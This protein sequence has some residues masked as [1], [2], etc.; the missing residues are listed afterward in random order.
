MLANAPLA[1]RVILKPSW[2]QSSQ[3]SSSPRPSPAA[4]SHFC[5]PQLRFDV[6]LIN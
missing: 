2:R 1:Q 6:A 4:R 3:T 5:T